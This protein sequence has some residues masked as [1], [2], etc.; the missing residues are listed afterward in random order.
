MIKINHKVEY[1]INDLSFLLILER[2]QRPVL[3]DTILRTCIRKTDTEVVKF[4]KKHGSVYLFRKLI[5]IFNKYKELGGLKSSWGAISMPPI[6]RRKK[7][8][9]V[10]AYYVP[11]APAPQNAAYAEG[12]CDCEDCIADRQLA[13]QEKEIDNLKHILLDPDDYYEEEEYHDHDEEE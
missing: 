10:P 12:E 1:D 13:A 2:L 5:E 11:I 4:F 9:D 6:S 8:L 7:I 3:D